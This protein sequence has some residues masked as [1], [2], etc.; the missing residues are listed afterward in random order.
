MLSRK[1]DPWASG[2]FLHANYETADVPGNNPCPW[3]VHGGARVISSWANV[4]RKMPVSFKGGLGPSWK[5]AG[6]WM[7]PKKKKHVPPQ[8]TTCQASSV[9][10]SVA[11]AV[12]PWRRIQ[13]T[14]N[15]TA[16]VRGSIAKAGHSSYSTYLFCITN[17]SIALACGSSCVFVVWAML[18]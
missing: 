15:R 3:R 10:F 5:R 13:S 7:A 12:P 2:I 1:H 11:L 18:S 6:V 17:D 14:E 16:W 8:C 9:T 4:D